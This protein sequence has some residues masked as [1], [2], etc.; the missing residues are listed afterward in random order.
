MLHLVSLHKNIKNS[1]FASNWPTGVTLPP[2]L[3]DSH[4]KLPQQ[5]DPHWWIACWVN[6]LSLFALWIYNS[7]P[8][9]PLKGLCNVMIFWTLGWVIVSTP[10]FLY[11]SRLQTKTYMDLYCFL[12][13]TIL[14][15]KAPAT[16]AIWIIQLF[17]YFTWPQTAHWSHI[18]KYFPWIGPTGPI[19]S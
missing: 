13:W 14:E 15:N 3:Y 2:I 12:Y 17:Q 4:L 5:G 19:Q 6:S 7:I 8:N 9:V 11:R 18:S 16:R 10:V 1:F